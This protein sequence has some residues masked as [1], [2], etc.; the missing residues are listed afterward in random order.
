MTN[1]KAGNA[2]KTSLSGAA[3]RAELESSWAELNTSPSERLDTLATLID[4]AEVTPEMAA[5]YEAIVSKL[6]ARLPITQVNP[7]ADMFRLKFRSILEFISVIL[8]LAICFL[9]DSFSYTGNVEK[10]VPGLQIKNCL[11]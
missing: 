6:A 8:F 9:L 1:G 3:L 2:K 5:K 11:S 10:T 4:D 7:S